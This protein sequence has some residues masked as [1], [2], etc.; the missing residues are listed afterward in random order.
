MLYQWKCLLGCKI[1]NFRSDEK[2]LTKTRNTRLKNRIFKVTHS[3]EQWSTGSDSSLFWEPS[4]SKP[5]TDSDAGSKSAFL[6]KE[7]S[8]TTSI[9]DWNLLTHELPGCVSDVVWNVSSFCKANTFLLLDMVKGNMTK[10][11]QWLVMATCVLCQVSRHSWPLWAT[12]PPSWE[13]VVA[14]YHKTTQLHCPTKIA[15]ESQRSQ[16][17][18][19][20]TQAVCNDEVVLYLLPFW[21]NL[22]HCRC[23]TWMFRNM[24]STGSSHKIDGIIPHMNLT[25]KSSDVL[26]ELS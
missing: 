8:K 14:R 6:T 18:T 25:W 12:V 21:C 19:L 11:L 3:S 1:Q 7:V 24:S 13:T 2:Q 9:V 20:N 15:V 23:G 17:V 10:F 4:D 22:V 26:D 5:W 16:A